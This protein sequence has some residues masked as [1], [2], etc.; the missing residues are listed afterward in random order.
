M[1]KSDK[2]CNIYHRHQEDPCPTTT[3]TPSASATGGTAPGG[4]TPR[5]TRVVPRRTWN[6]IPLRSHRSLRYATRKV[7]RTGTNA[8]GS[9]LPRSGREKVVIRF[10]GILQGQRQLPISPLSEVSQSPDR[11]TAPL[12]R[13]PL[14]GP[15]EFGSYV[16]FRTPH[17]IRRIRARSPT[18][19]E[20]QQPLTQQD[21]P[22][23]AAAAAT[24]AAASAGELGG[25]HRGREPAQPQI[26]NLQAANAQ[27]TDRT[28]GRRTPSSP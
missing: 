26:Q 14:D 13:T 5:T 11:K 21:G 7:P 28:G 3:G 24:A 6:K 25:R 19:E 4:T 2:W 27:L 17:G 18:P 20:E 16:Y 12:I 8:I 9:S 10:T 15:I 1:V 23:P 22:E